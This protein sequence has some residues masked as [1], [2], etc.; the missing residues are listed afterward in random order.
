MPVNHESLHPPRLRE[1]LS[2]WLLPPRC[3][4]CGE[5]CRDIDLCDACRAALPRNEPA[6][7]RCALPLAA[8]APACGACLASPP[9]FTHAI[10][11]WRYEGPIARLL[12]RLKFQREL[13]VA[14]TLATLAAHRIAGWPG[15]HNATRLIPMP[16]HAARLGQRGYNQ[17]LELTHPLARIQALPT[18]T[19]TLTRTR[20]TAPQTDLD[21]TERRRNLRG[22]FVAEKLAGEI[23]VLVDDVITTGATAREAAR[24]LLRAGV[25]EVRL[26]AVAR[27]P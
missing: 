22:A 18:D 2:R 20:P 26:V 16:L 17:A 23:V 8:S 15:W 10:A 13:A 6:C 19:T 24:T 27:A 14:H 5:P 3:L 1:R 4:A 25:A 21:A 9:P 7:P 12:P 11:P